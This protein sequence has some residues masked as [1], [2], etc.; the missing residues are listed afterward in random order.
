MNK[1]SI[2]LSR[3]LN[4][5]RTYKAEKERDD[6][7]RSLVQTSSHFDQLSSEKHGLTIALDELRRR[8]T[9]SDSNPRLLLRS[10][11]EKFDIEKQN[12]LDELDMLQRARTTFEH[13][14][15]TRDQELQKIRDRSRVAADE[16]KSALA[17]IAALEQ[18]VGAER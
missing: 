1:N 9:M 17:K 16:L 6:L 11:S 7:Q 14:K 4:D 18:Q 2:V 15:R 8:T 12:L 5:D 10:L 3:T 13:D